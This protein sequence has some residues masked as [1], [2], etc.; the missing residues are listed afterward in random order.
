MGS[1][2][3]SANVRRANHAADHLRQQHVALLAA[4]SPDERSALAIAV[5]APT[6][7]LVQA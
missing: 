2:I 7:I 5:A 6:R 4:L 1:H 3:S